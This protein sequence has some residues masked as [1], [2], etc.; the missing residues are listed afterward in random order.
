MW[1]ESRLKEQ[2][3]MGRAGAMGE[4]STVRWIQL[5]KSLT[6]EVEPQDVG[7]WEQSGDGGERQE[8]EEQDKV[9]LQVCTSSLKGLAKDA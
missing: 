8:D 1:V 5:Q 6:R 4:D 2:H 9:I 3:G 7:C